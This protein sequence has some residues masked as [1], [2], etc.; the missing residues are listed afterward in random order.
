MC[1]YGGE[2]FHDLRLRNRV[3]CLSIFIF[4]QTVSSNMNNFKSNLHDPFQMQVS[5]IKMT[6]LFPDD[7]VNETLS[8]TLLKD[9]SIPL[10]ITI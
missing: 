5:V 2:L 8:V 10:R 4:F 3:H 7:G 9:Y 6:I 1:V